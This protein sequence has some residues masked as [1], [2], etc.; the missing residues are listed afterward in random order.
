MTI[1]NK[2]CEKHIQR[3]LRGR[4]IVI[5]D[6]IFS[7]YTWKLRFDVRTLRCIGDT[8]MMSIHVRQL[9]LQ[10]YRDEDLGFPSLHKFESYIDEEIYRIL[11]LYF[12][13]LQIYINF[14]Q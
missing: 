5:P 3:I 11:G 13:H 8:I 9:H 2:Y 14:T 1:K 12:G 7:D 4:V 10:S 6:Y